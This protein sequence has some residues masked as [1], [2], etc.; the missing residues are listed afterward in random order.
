M[1]Q[2]GGS[3]AQPVADKRWTE[4]VQVVMK[5]HT[6]VPLAPKQLRSS[7][8]TLELMS[9]EN[10]DGAQQQAVA[11]AM[12]H[13]TQQQAG[14]AYDKERSERLW[15]AAVNVT[16]AYAARACRAERAHTP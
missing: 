6:G 8:I 16:A 9:D 4:T 2:H 10:T 11:H 1:G 14:P 13:S 7:F 3:H 5:R 12:R 15:A